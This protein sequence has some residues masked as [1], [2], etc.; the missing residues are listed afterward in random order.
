MK[1]RDST[2][3]L[4]EKISY[5]KKASMADILTEMCHICVHFHQISGDQSVDIYSANVIR[6][7][8]PHTAPNVSTPIV[9]C[10]FPCQ[11]EIRGR[12]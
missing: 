1:Y 11:T 5:G 10:R 12:V 6:H 8:L 4:C 9:I 7:Y 2:I 3:F